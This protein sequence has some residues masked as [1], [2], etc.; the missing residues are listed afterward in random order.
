MSHDFRDISIFGFAK[1]SNIQN[2][3]HIRRDKI[4]LKIGVDTPQKYPPGPKIRQNRSISHDFRDI[5]IFV[6]CTF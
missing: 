1:N 6:F 3:R 5:S 2:G 4:F